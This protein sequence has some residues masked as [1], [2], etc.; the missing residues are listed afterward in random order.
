MLKAARPEKYRERHQLEH[1]VGGGLVDAIAG[2]VAQHLGGAELDRF[3][4]DLGQLVE[5][6]SN[7][8]PQLTGNGRATP[9]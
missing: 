9:N 6:V 2:L 7:A 8:T 3:E 5:G 1:N 4:R